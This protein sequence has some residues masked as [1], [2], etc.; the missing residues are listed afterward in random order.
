MHIFYILIYYYI[1]VHSDPYT[2]IYTKI[3]EVV[4]PSSRKFSMACDT[5]ELIN[6]RNDGLPTG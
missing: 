4:M 1:Y 6:I 5:D 2:Y 3:F